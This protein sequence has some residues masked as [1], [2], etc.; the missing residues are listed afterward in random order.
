MSRNN[1]NRPALTHLVRKIVAFALLGAACAFAP[2]AFAQDTGDIVIA[3]LKGDVRV[4]MKGSERAVRAGAVL[5]LPA[6][7]Q[8]G[9][10]GA[11]DLR[12][13]ATTVS[14]GPDTVL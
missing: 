1:H 13:G 9:R 5:E 7:V 14:V 10:D 11:V 8:T 12:Q 4:T 3:K 2:A 6:T